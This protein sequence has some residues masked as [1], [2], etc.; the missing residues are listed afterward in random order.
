[1]RKKRQRDTVSTRLTVATE[2]DSFYKGK[3]ER[4]K[5]RDGEGCE[6]SIE[7]TG[8]QKEE[9]RSANPRRDH[10]RPLPCRCNVR[11]V[12]VQYGE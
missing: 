9:E 1:M 4:G 3:R 12:Q 6:E 8:G 11:L 5:E 2:G 7:E 10:G